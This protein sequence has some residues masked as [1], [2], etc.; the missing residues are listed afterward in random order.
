MRGMSSVKRPRN[1]STSVALDEGDF[2][3]F[4]P[5]EADA[6]AWCHELTLLRGGR[7]IGRWR[8]FRG[9]A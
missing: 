8:T 3:F 6:V 9:G 5:W 7:V 1:G 2:I 4:D